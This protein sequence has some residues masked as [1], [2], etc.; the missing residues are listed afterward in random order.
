LASFVIPDLLGTGAEFRKKFELPILRGRDAEASLEQRKIGE[1][2]LS[3]LG[4]IVSKFII[5]RTADLLTKYLPTK[6]EYIVFVKLTDFQRDLYSFYSQKEM[7]RLR[8]EEN[9]SSGKK[10]GTT[11]LQAM[12]TM[13]KIVNHPGLLD[14]DVIPSHISCEGFVPSEYSS[15]YAGKFILL[16]Q[17]LHQ[18]RTE[19]KDKIVLISNYT[20]TLDFMVKLAALRKWPFVRLD[21][22]MTIPK[23]QKIVDK[24]NNPN[25]PEFIFLLSSKAGGCGINLVFKILI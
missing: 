3:E 1:E 7:N 8:K 19:T 11:A 16:D 24:F 21:G 13:K 6:Y 23:R 14:K 10:G 25:E 20:Q 9:E 18:I 17:M 15:K 4:E 5:R 2:K 22:S 12:T